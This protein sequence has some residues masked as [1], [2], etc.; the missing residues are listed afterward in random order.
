MPLSS[1]QSGD[2]EVAWKWVASPVMSRRAV[3]AGQDTRRQDLRRP[4]GDRGPML[5]KLAV[6]GER[7]LAAGTAGALIDHGADRMAVL[8]VAQAMEDDLGDRHLAVLALAAG[9]VIHDLGEAA[10]LLE[11][12][13]HRHVGGAGHAPRTASRE[14]APGRALRQPAPLRRRA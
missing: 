2:T 5:G 6:A 14:R 9:F 1:A 11:Q 7:E 3:W 10:M 13:R 8:A 12:L 4:P